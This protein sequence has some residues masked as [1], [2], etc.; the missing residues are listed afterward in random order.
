MALCRFAAAVAVS[1]AAIWGSGIVH[2]GT[3][4]LPYAKG[5]RFVVT[6]G[7][8]ALPTHIKKDA[9]ALDFAQGGCDAYGKEVV[10]A[11][12]GVAM[13]V[14]EEGYNGG[15][16][17]ELIIDHGDALVSRYAHMI[18]GSITVS[19]GEAIRPGET[20][21]LLGNS[22]LT[23][24]AACAGHPGT[25][26]HFAMDTIAADG[27]YHARNPE[28]ISGYTGIKEGESYWSDNGP[29]SGEVA[30]FHDAVSAGA[31]AGG[32]VLGVST[33]APLPAEA[34]APPAASLPIVASVSEQT[35]EFLPAPPPPPSAPSVPALP[36]GGVSIVAIVP[37]PVPAP[38]AE[39]VSPPEENGN[40]G[41]AAATSTTPALFAQEIDADLSPASW[42]DDNWFEL[43]N[44]FSGTL[45]SLILEGK[46]NDP[47]YAA[48]H[49]SL[50]EFKDPA[51]TAMVRQFAIA[52]GAL[53]TDAM[54]K[55]T[56]DDL[57]IAL[58]PYFY[59]RIATVQDWQNRSVILAGTAST[60]AGTA[61]GNEFLYGTG[62]V[63][64]TSTFFPYL[65]MEGDAATSTAVAPRITPPSDI[66]LGLD[67]ENMWLELMFAVSSDPEWPDNPLHYE[68]AYAT[69]TSLP[70]EGWV[71]VGTIPVVFGNDYLIGIRA[72]DDF[73]GVSE[74]ATATWSFPPDFSPYILSPGLPYAAQWFDVSMTS[75]LRS[76]QIFTT[77]LQTNLRMPDNLQ[78]TLSLYDSFHDASYGNTPSDYAVGGYGCA[79]DP[80]FSFASSSLVLSPSHHY[81][82]IFQAPTGNQT[83]YASVQFYGKNIDTVGGA[84][85]DPSLANA[86]FKV[87]G[88]AGVLVAN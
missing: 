45:R 35:P 85:S 75:T 38:A 74:I 48:S 30:G 83:T 17:T 70:D 16:G 24:G 53:F 84:F 32:E 15:Y 40:G 19:A 65:I 50:Q 12:P 77:N 51:Y 9:Y 69:S 10:A 22:G 27:N 62:R 42:Y 88:D 55:I 71:P 21:G 34:P 54:A 78:C 5:E 59:Y 25:H 28:P 81:Q 43:G 61:M 41:P 39:P 64:S 73:G 87:T 33:E 3:V 4:K 49:V 67:E 82:W 56:F 47:H 52:D 46:I 1:G 6:Q 31:M 18:P 20:V 68:M 36:S 2:A 72:M 7:Y 29:D 58:K 63:E 60:S 23:A 66:A 76:I 57:G 8:A 80:V 14:G 79:D 44:G 11:A 86:R 26:L 13:F 37:A